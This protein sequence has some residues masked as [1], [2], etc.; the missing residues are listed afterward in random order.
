MNDDE[1]PDDNFLLKHQLSSLREV[2]G[3]LMQISMSRDDPC[4]FADRI[5]GDCNVKLPEVVASAVQLL[6]SRIE[7]AEVACM[8]LKTPQSQIAAKS[9]CITN[10]SIP[11]NPIVYLS[12]SFLQLSGYVAGDVLGKPCTFLQGQDT[13]PRQVNTYCIHTYGTIIVCLRLIVFVVRF[14]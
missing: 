11:H 12:R 14:Q 10:A 1:S 13:D 7:K 5:L 2:N 3:H 4:P 8:Q 6:I 9:F